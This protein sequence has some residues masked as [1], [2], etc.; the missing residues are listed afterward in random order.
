M[1]GRW[2]RPRPFL[3]YY[4]EEGGRVYRSP[5]QGTSLPAQEK[6]ENPCGWAA[7]ALWRVQSKGSLLGTVI[8]LPTEA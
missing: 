7:M 6:E 2:L 3:A 1:E 8:F 4:P 5:F